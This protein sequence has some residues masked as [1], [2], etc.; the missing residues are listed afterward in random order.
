MIN[1]FD[2]D[3]ILISPAGISYIDSRKQINI[4]DENGFLPL[5]T[6]PM[7]TVVSNSN[8]NIFFKNKIYHII[9]RNEKSSS[10]DEW[11]AISLDDFE[12]LYVDGDEIPKNKILIDI[13]NGG[14]NRLLTATRSSKEKYGNKL[15]LMVGNIANPETYKLLSDAGA[16]YIRCGIGNGSGC[17]TTQQTGIG[18]PMAS[19]IRECY[20][21]SLDLKTP[22]K[23]VADGGFKKYSDVIKALALGSDYVMLGSILNKCLESCADTHIKD[24]KWDTPGEL[25]DQYSDETKQMF[26][27]GSKF[28]KKFRGM[29]T[30]EAQ[31]SMG[32]TEL[33]TSEGITRMNQ[34]EYTLEGWT[35]NFKHYL[36]SAMSYTDKSDLKEFIGGVEYNMI[37][38]NAFNRFS[39]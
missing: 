20:N 27:N 35:D 15:T 6:A 5:F 7:D 34:V 12:K 18:Y 21:I 30:K 22:A 26:N 3:D 13:A 8:A 33:K 9:P 38:E 31:K 10:P 16:D 28:F 25:V 2:F 17:L 32:K 29:S 24:V 39:K 4:F 36:A 23:I 19:L 37:T 11:V 14:M 1:K